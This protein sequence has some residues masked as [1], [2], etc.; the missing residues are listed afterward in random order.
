MSI[1]ERAA[2]VSA[3][4]QHA[5]VRRARGEQATSA[6]LASLGKIVK[7]STGE[8]P[9]TINFMGLCKA[10]K[11]QLQSAMMG[12]DLLPSATKPCTSIPTLYRH[13]AD[14]ERCRI[15]YA[16]YDDN[17]R[18]QQS[19]TPD[20]E[21]TAAECRLHLNGLNDGARALAAGLAEAAGQEEAGDCQ[22]DFVMRE[23]QLA[24]VPMYTVVEVHLMGL[25]E[26]G[27]PEEVLAKCQ[28]VDSPGKG[29]AFNPVVDM[30]IRDIT[31]LSDLIVVLMDY[32]AL[33]TSGDG[34]LWQSLEE[35]RP[36]LLR[37]LGDRCLYFISH[38]DAGGAGAMSVEEACEHARQKVA[39]CIRAL[40][41]IEQFMGGSGLG[42]AAA[43]HM[44]R[45]YREGLEPSEEVFR[46]AI[47][48]MVDADCAE[49]VTFE[50]TLEEMS[51]QE[52][53]DTLEY[54]GLPKLERKLAERLLRLEDLRARI[55]NTGLK[56]ITDCVSSDLKAT[57]ESLERS[58]EA[59]QAHQAALTSVI[60]RV[61]LYCAKDIA[62]SIA[63]GK[64]AALKTITTTVRDIETSLKA[65]AA[66]YVKMA[67][68][69]KKVVFENEAAAQAYV[70]KRAAE[71]SRSLREA[72]AA[73]ADGLREVVGAEV[74]HVISNFE[75][76]I[77]ASFQAYLA[78]A[79]KGLDIDAP[80]LG[81]VDLGK[82]K[83]EKESVR[84]AVAA[85]GTIDD[86][87]IRKGI[88]TFVKAN[89]YTEKTT[90][91]KTRRVCVGSSGFW[92]WKRKRYA[93]Q[94]YQVVVKVKRTNYPVQAGAVERFVHKLYLANL[95][96]V[97]A[98]FTDAAAGALAHI[99][100]VLTAAI[101]AP[102][103]SAKARVDLAL[104]SKGEAQ[105]VQ[106]N[107]LAT[108][109]QQQ[110]LLAGVTE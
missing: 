60:A 85:L 67:A 29:E 90:Q 31:A 62:P 93:N 21:G 61:Q 64:A 25:V 40:P 88:R 41:S 105:D 79:F 14:R 58:S 59:L 107:L 38:T 80:A 70:K 56:S 49:D 37:E 43:R 78:E 73:K 53:Q 68:R 99:D 36:D 35:Q 11:S 6:A 28:F 106:K 51:E 24:G 89:N 71:I 8:L 45:Y 54:W 52:W 46:G 4:A 77:L 95:A 12:R 5:T 47:A 91:V 72:F 98:H 15:F 65:T 92:F 39:E 2:V 22:G 87:E 42:S 94:A 75:S 101:N 102:L 19:E 86:A 100:T 103:A 97:K 48:P 110:A 16:N 81:D 33:G 1:S 13:S 109:C 17:L 9:I 82:I 32:R 76:V 30:T 66:S 55:C 3:V 50:E 63:K 69:G 7:K 20:F 57:I 44:L 18:V 104:A 23:M 26:A 108:L 34:A 84:K 10:G 74:G 83:G 96:N 27:V